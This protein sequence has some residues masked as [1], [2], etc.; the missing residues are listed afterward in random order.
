[1][2]NNKFNFN[3]YLY[4]NRDRDIFYAEDDLK[5]LRSIIQIYCIKHP[6]A[7]GKEIK[8]NM[9]K[10]LN[11]C[12]FDLQDCSSPRSE[13]AK[14]YAYKRLKHDKDLFKRTYKKVTSGDKKNE[15]NNISLSNSYS[16]NPEQANEMLLKEFLRIERNF[17]IYSEKNKEFYL[18]NKERVEKYIMEKL[19]AIY[20]K[21]F[22]NK[23]KGKDDDA[24]YTLLFSK[25]IDVPNEEHLKENYI[26]IIK[27]VGERL[28]Q[29]GELKKDNENNNKLMKKYDMEGLEYPMES[30]NEAETIGVKDIFKKENLEN[31]SLLQI[32][33]IET[34]WVNRYAKILESLSNSLMI[35]DQFDL[36]DKLKNGEKI[37]LNEDELKYVFQKQNILY[38]LS[39][40]ISDTISSTKSN[41][42]KKETQS[43]V[44]VDA[45]EIFNKIYKNMGSKYNKHFSEMNPNFEN[46]LVK[47]FDN[48][49][50]YNS[51][52]CIIYQMK[53]F[54]MEAIIYNIVNA[55]R[56][57]NWGVI[58]N[59]VN[60]KKVVLS[61]DVPELNMPL[62]LHIEK[63]KLIQFFDEYQGNAII[64]KYDGAND[65]E[66]EGRTL[67][68]NVLMLLGNKQKDFIKKEL[69]EDEEIKSGK[70]KMYPRSKKEINFLEHINYLGNIEEYPKHLGREF[71][72]KVKG[73]KITGYKQKPYEYIDLA[74]LKKY[75][76]D[77]NQK[78]VEIQETRMRE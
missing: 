19:G 17:K 21:Y 10:F 31:L 2:E 70:I 59:T 1:M 76:K 58:E 71:V 7:T 52:K 25:D 61:A 8:E 48:F 72:K 23:C 26:K 57:L 66:L 53:D 78:F 41:E 50:D 65:F 38:G 14:Y 3:R 73:K 35:A 37:T 29:F 43:I 20:L 63:E 69:K 22:W 64:P 40:D 4:K 16:N 67:P 39:R 42:M 15:Q 56:K 9:R 51:A 74:T 27:K 32:S 33:S 45:D 11:N 5:L 44:T 24:L 49:Y 68:T 28:E 46:D 54:S 18:N 12:T 75:K 77:E 13:T 36:F 62:R 34:F 47:D 6:N 30:D 55:G 60:N